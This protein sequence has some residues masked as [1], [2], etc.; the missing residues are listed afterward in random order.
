MNYFT[1]L[2]SPET[3]KAFSES[4]RTVTGFRKR[5]RRQASR[6]KPGDMLLCYVTRLSRWVGILEVTSRAFEDETPIFVSVDDP[7]SVRFR[8]KAT[9]WLDLER[10]IPVH[11]D[12]LWDR[13]TFTRGL[14]KNSTAWT[15]KVRASLTLID[16]RDAAVLRETLK[17]ANDKSYVFPLSDNDV[18]QLHPTRARKSPHGRNS[19]SIPTPSG[20]STGGEPSP[21]DSFPIQALL[22]MIGERMGFKIWIPRGDRSRVLAHWQPKTCDTIIDSLPLNYNEATLATVELID[23]LW[24]SSRTIV[25][26]FEVE[27]TTSVYSG[28]LRMA[29]LLA[30]QPN[31]EIRAHIVA[32]S[33]R[34]ER[35]MHEITRP[36][37]AHLGGRPLARACTYLSY[38][39]VSDLAS[40]ELL[41]H[42]SE[43]V[44]DKF[45][46][47]A[48]S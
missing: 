45:S 33:G 17:Q 8:V 22:A 34:R 6:V 14:P 23:V 5:Q 4:D 3:Y 25:R 43:T 36:A 35:V 20:D 2:F 24:L 38:Q 40:Q 30:L 19:S 15:G 46:E 10:S 18:R 12:S 41:E 26:A 31:I 21:S 28:I 7:F 48:E 42:M 47:E 13:L 32:P 27:H 37:F 39:A 1:D 29:D 9:L 16:T 11:D 44:V